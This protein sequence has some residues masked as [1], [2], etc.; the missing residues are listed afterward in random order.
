MKILLDNVNVFSNSGPNHFGSKLIKYL[1][2][3]GN[4]CMLPPQ[5]GADVNLAFNEYNFLCIFYVI[6]KATKD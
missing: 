6:N 4:Q 5:E 3:R 2:K 1:D